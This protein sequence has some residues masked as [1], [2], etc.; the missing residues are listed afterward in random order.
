MLTETRPRDVQVAEI[1]PGVL[2]LRSRTW[3]RLKFEVE[4]GRQQGTTSNSYLIRAPQPALLD[5]PGESF[6]QIYLQELQQHIDLSQLRYLILS[7]VNSNRLA[8]VKVLLEKAPQIIIVCSK[9][10]AVTLRSTLGEQLNLWIPRAE[11]PLEL[12]AIANWSLLL[13][14]RPAGPM[15]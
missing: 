7:H 5:P 14:L 9:A 4:Y 6:T 2:V 10:G 1:A 13:L 12:G 15:A 3:D 11:T 8:T